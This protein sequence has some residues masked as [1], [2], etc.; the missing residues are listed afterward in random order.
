MSVGVLNCLGQLGGSFII[1]G[2]LSSDVYI[3]IVAIAVL[4]VSNQQFDFITAIHSSR[5]CMVEFVGPP[6]VTLTFLITHLER[7]RSILSAP[8]WTVFTRKR[9]AGREFSTISAKGHDVAMDG[10]RLRLE[11]LRSRKVVKCVLLDTR[12][13]DIK[14]NGYCMGLVVF[15]LRVCDTFIQG[16]NPFMYVNQ[17][18]GSLLPTYRL[19]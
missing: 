13:D 18:T 3:R 9:T 17:K 4:N 1:D 11:M 19:F 14:Y 12:V 15:V 10:Y 6:H 16:V 8:G 7:N 5:M 2:L